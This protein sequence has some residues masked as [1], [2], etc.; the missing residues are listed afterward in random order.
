[1]PVSELAEARSA[2]RAWWIFAGVMLFA[3]AVR[4]GALWAMRDKL[5]ADPDS[6]RQLAENLLAEGVYG[7]FLPLDI[8]ARGTSK[9]P[10]A[11]RPPLYPLLL[12]KLAYSGTVSLAAVAACHLLLGLLTVAIVYWLAASRVSVVAAPIAAL[13]ATCDPI[14]LF[15][16]AQVM[17]ETLATLL[18]VCCWWQLT[19]FSERRT[20]GNALAC[21][22]LVGLAALCRPTFLL[23]ALPV[24]VVVLCWQLPWR[25]KLLLATTVSIGVLAAM[26]PWAIRNYR[27]FGEAKFTT[28]HGGYTLWLANNPSYYD[29]LQSGKG[30]AWPGFTEEEQ[31]AEVYKVTKFFVLSGS[32]SQAAER[33]WHDWSQI[34]ALELLEFDA[35]QEFHDRAVATIRE[36]PG[37]FLYSS[38]VRVGYLWSPLP[39]KTTL[40]ESTYRVLAR[41]LVAIWYVGVYLLAMLGIYKL[42]GNLLRSPWVWGLTLCLVF[43][44]VHAVYWSNLRMRAP[45]MPVVSLL[46]G[47][48]IAVSGK[49]IEPRRHGDTEKA[50]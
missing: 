3:L 19:R 1:M 40:S 50:G 6:Y 33:A 23:W 48:G 15:Q 41:Y 24:G 21:G 7:R 30:S 32:N 43:T 27:T 2:R 17:T 8:H 46:A 16:S 49:V 39:Q 26:S 31:T 14:L 22:A 47:A 28:T 45:L 11:Y 34:Y 38:L 37:M 4:G 13:I 5:A 25:H 20:L 42:R 29:W 35:D 44:A 12:T 36:R 18:A 9:L 10:T